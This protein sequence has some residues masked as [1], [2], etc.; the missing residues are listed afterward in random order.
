M[1]P[2]D[3]VLLDGGMG[4]EL[5]HRGAARADRLWGAQVMIDS[6][7][8][9]TRLHE[10]YIRAG[11]RVITL[12]TYSV[13]PERLADVGREHEFSRLQVLA[14]ELAAAA[15]A[16]CGVVDVKIA[17]SLPPLYDS[18]HPQHAP[19]FEQALATYRAIVAEQKGAVDLFICETMSSIHEA[20]A[21]ATAASESDLPVWVALS[22][23]DECS[24]TLR[25]GETIVDAREA[26][27][28][29]APQA[30]L[31]N[32]SLPEAVDAA[33]SQM[34]AL[35]CAIGAYANGFTS[36]MPME[37]G[38]SV[39]A[40]QARQDLDPQAYAAFALRWADS[41][42]AIVGGCCEITPAHIACLADVLQ[43][44]GYR[45]TGDVPV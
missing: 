10:D 44:A 2:R 28:A 3:I 19:P 33:W 1:T 32:C 18:Y 7:E 4:Q 29:C 43:S 13:T 39:D 40:L 20:K 11:A 26:L 25:S 45:I 24:G 23:D 6:P 21:A 37:Y 31:L 12:N 16:R 22:V 36:V 30:L 17:A 42:G 41:G 5:A 15:R 27:R 9:V 14:F 38:T 8:L 34:R 35:D